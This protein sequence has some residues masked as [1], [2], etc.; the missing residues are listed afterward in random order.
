MVDVNDPPAEDH[1][2]E[3][4][5]TVSTTVKY[6]PVKPIMGGIVSAE[7]NTAWTGG[8]PKPDWSGLKVIVLQP[9]NPCQLRY[10]TGKTA[11]TSYGY[12]IEGLSVQLSCIKGLNTFKRSVCQHMTKWGMDSIAYLPDPYDSKEVVHIV[13]GFPCFSLESCQT[14]S[15]IQRKKYDSYDKENDAAAVMFLLLSLSSNLCA[16]S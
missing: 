13:D 7:Y 14:A 6:K 3:Q 8:V 9:A 16:R 12:R 11:T 5:Q 4:D 2:E 15:K 10:P 1:E